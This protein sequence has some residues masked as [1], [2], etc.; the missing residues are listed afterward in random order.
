MKAS[1]DR[2]RGPLHAGE[3]KALA[4]WMARD[5]DVVVFEATGL[6][7]QGLFRAAAGLSVQVG[8]RAAVRRALAARVP[9]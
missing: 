7:R 4:E 6:S 3:A 2:G 5:G 8:T 9:T 1:Q